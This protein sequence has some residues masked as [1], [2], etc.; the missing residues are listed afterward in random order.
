MGKSNNID[1]YVFEELNTDPAADGRSV[2]DDVN[3]IYREVMG[4]STPTN[5]K[6]CPSQSDIEEAIKSGISKYECNDIIMSLRIT[7]QANL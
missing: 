4:V 5:S 3:K 2:H 1:P 6:N 7:P